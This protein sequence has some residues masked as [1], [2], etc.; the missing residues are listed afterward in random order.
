MIPFLLQGA[1]ALAQNQSKDENAAKEVSQEVDQS[2]QNEPFSL[3]GSFDMLVD[4]MSGWVDSI[5]LKLPNFI[6]AVIVFIIFWFLAKYVA[7]LID[8]LLRHSVRQ[9]SVRMVSVKVV[10]VIVVM[11]G[12]FVALGIMDLN[13]VLTT[14]L[15]AA[16]VIG[17]AVGLALQGILNNSFSGVLLSFLPKIEIGDWVVTN[18]IEG[19]ITEITLRSITV[20]KADNNIVVIPNSLI[21]EAPFENYSHTARKRIIVECGVGYESD[22]EMVRDVTVE[23][24]AD[25]FPQKDGEEV[26]FFYQEFGS[27]SINYVLRFWADASKKRDIHV[28]RNE[29]VMAIHKLYNEKDINIPFP[30]RT[31]DFDKNKFRA[32]TLTVENRS[33]GN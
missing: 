16:G 4:K 20:Q 13:Q 2:A 7:K 5:V 29:A 31:L 23:M 14:I 21:V 6:L 17:L 15:G 18:D 8:R 22:L 11:I 33:A 24:I 12:F 19:K 32:E 26:E 10:K 25:K 27:S 30:I 9:D 3:E 28:L 1:Q